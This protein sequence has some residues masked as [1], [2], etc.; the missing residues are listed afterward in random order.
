MEC[1]IQL[2][3]S[4]QC[5]GVVKTPCGELHV[6]ENHG[7]VDLYKLVAEQPDSLIGATIV[8]K[9]IGRGAAL[10]LVKGGI[11]RAHAFTMSQGAMQVLR[12]AGIDATCDAL[13]DHIINRAGDGMC[14]VERA[15][16]DTSDPDEAMRRIK[17]FLL[18]NGI[19]KH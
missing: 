15:T 2:V 5:R 16:L 19:L 7:V 11:A 3:K 8:D 1:L 14:P 17:A 6:F 12:D 9:V 18:S 10:L 13:V 4:T